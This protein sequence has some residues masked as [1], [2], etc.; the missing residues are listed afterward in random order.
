MAW[1]P[2][3]SPRVG[4][5]AP[6]P[7]PCDYMCHFTIWSGCLYRMA[8]VRQIGF[9]NVD[10]VLDGGEVGYAY[11][12]MKA[13]YKAFIHQHARMAHNIR[14]SASLV[15][16][17][18]EIGPAKMTFYEFPP[19]RCYYACR[20]LLYFSL[21]DRQE[22]RLWMTL[23]TMVG[24]I[25]S[26]LNF[27]LRPHNR[28]RELFACLRG[29][30]HGVTGTLRPDI[31]L[32][33]AIEMRILA[34][35]HA[36]NDG[37][38]IDGTIEALLRQTRPVDGI[39]VVDN[40]ST[41]DTLERLSLKHATV[42]QHNKN[43]GTSGAVRSGFCFALEHGYD[44]IWLF[45]ADSVPDPDALQKLLDLYAGWS[46][47]LREKTAFLACLPVA[48]D[49]TPRHGGSLPPMVCASR[50]DAERAVL[51]LSYDDLVRLSVSAGG[52]PE[53]RSS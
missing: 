32:R 43:I 24:L 37:D 10:Y 52:G 34:H 16:T 38:I 42:L 1:R 18:V 44:W 3:Y 47:D 25:K 15:Q 46:T 45:D 20:N 48:Q 4:A 36:L 7:Y 9:P 35:I 39:L 40:G 28:R 51:L 17:E 26:I 11:L 6:A 49:G 13:G 8:A 22:G 41:G 53:Y 27:L 21:Y 23:S 12:V 14:G 31:E 50:P 30:W 33:P 29:I 5:G 19:I 2:L